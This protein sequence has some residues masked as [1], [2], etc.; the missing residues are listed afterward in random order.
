MAARTKK[1]ACHVPPSPLTQRLRSTATLMPR[2]TLERRTLA[3]GT[4]A[5]I[6]HHDASL[7]RADSRGAHGPSRLYSRTPTSCVVH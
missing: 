2:F 4:V 7:H 6:M 3:L 5:G 1:A